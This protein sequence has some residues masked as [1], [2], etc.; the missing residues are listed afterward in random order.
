[1]ASGELVVFQQV[2]FGLAVAIILDA[3][4]IRMVLVPASMELLGERNWYFPY[5]LEWLPRINIE[6]G[7]QAEP[8]EGRTP[9]AVRPS[10]DGSQEA[11]ANAG[12][13]KAPQSHTSR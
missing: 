13:V 5:W 3:T 11:V 2:G 7:F 6:G 9:S 4:I 12:F 8:A 10:T 1:M